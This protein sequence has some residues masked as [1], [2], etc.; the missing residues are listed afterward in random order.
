ML[1][2]VGW[3]RKLVR[4]FT[5]MT[6]NTRRMLNTEPGTHTRQVLRNTVCRLAMG[7]AGVTDMGAFSNDFHVQR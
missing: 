1:M 7:F 4:G 2:L 3:V 5:S 6:K